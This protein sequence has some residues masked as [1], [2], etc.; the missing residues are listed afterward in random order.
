[1]WQAAHWAAGDVA[2]ASPAAAGARLWVLAGRPAFRAD[3]LET[4]E[5]FLVSAAISVAGGVGLGAV[6]G[7]SRLAAR[8]VEPVLSSLYALP[9]VTLYPVVLLLFG[10]GSPAQVAFGVMHGLL[11]IG[12]I[13]MNAVLQVRPIHLRTALVL[14]LSTAQTLSTVVLPSVLP[15]VLGGV[16]IGLPLALLGVLIGEMFAGRRGLGS[17]VMRAMEANDGPTL[18][19]VALLLSVAALALDAAARRVG[20]DGPGRGRGAELVG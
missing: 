10:L 13:T 18:L 20:G 17:V 6:L 19:A 9:K 12:L 8:V 1:M 14:R 16:R 4:V 5:A 2:L 3:A 15:E 7:L 11:P